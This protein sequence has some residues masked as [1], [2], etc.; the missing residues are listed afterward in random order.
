MRVAITGASGY[1]GSAVAE[2]FRQAGHDV[3]ALIRSR[4]KSKG[5]LK[6]EIVPIIGDLKQPNDLL[7]AIKNADAF[8]HC[9]FD[10]T[11]PAAAEIPLLEILSEHQ[12]P[13]FIYT[14]GVWVL[15]NSGNDVLDERT[16]CRPIELAKWRHSH[17]E[18]VLSMK[19]PGKRTVIL[20]PGCV[21][22]EGGGGDGGL[23]SIWF[24][25][26][27]TGAIVFAGNG[28]NRWSMIHVRDLARAYVLAAESDLNGTAVNIVDD[29]RATVK[30][31]ALACA[32][33]AG[34]PGKVSSLSEEE[35]FKRYGAFAQGMLIDQQVSDAF[36]R[37][38]LG[39]SPLHRGFIAEAD[40]YF[41]AWQAGQA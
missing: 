28:E 27:K 24:A 2:A 32:A 14:S 6:R 17:E 29:S 7:K 35:S 3:H 15:G 1:I 33:A 41:A 8:I 25:S 4:E 12:P 13:L 30:E 9:A 34:I 23:T 36:A 18:R 19:G 40:K 20:R 22:G 16:P 26:A 21:F 10:P 39:W 5:L 11:G 38:S 31:M 37:K